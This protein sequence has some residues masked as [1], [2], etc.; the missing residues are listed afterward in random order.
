VDERDA[1]RRVLATLPEEQRRALLLTSY[2]GRTAAEIGEAESIPLGTAKTRIR[3]G[4]RRLRAE[5][6]VGDG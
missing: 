1:L 3:T 2:F 5:L 4:M 6:E